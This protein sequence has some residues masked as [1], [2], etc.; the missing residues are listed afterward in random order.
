MIY[1]KRENNTLTATINDTTRTATLRT[2]NRWVFTQ[3]DNFN[4]G[5]G[6]TNFSIT[7]AFMGDS[8][9]KSISIADFLATAKTKTATA[10][11]GKTKTATATNHE[12]TMLNLQIAIDCVKSKTEMIDAGTATLKDLQQLRGVYTDLLPK[13]APQNM[14]K[15]LDKVDWVDGKITEMKKAEEEKRQAEKAEEEKLINAL[16]DLL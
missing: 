15:W 11:A 4:I 10:T 16:L 13:Y 1:L 3:S 7:L 2:D 9:D 6:K 8:T 14:A 12:K 5:N